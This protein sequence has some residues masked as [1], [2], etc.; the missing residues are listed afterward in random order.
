M[1]LALGWQGFPKVCRLLR[2]E[3]VGLDLLPSLLDT[4]QL[5]RQAGLQSLLLS[6]HSS[7]SNLPK[8]QI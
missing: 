1:G 8:Y 7:L 2:L 6:L 3:V 5:S 4:V